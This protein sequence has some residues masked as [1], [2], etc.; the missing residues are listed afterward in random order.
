MDLNPSVFRRLD[1]MPGGERLSERDKVALANLRD[2]SGS[3]RNR[4]PFSAGAICPDER[5][6]I[7]APPGKP[8][9]FAR[10]GHGGI[11]G[12]GTF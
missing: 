12:Q 8:Q 11:V 1:T 9:L 10:I 2:D 3:M 5:T 7:P 4:P 6:A